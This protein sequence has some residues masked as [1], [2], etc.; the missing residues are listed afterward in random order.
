MTGKFEVRTTY[1]RFEQGFDFKFRLKM[2]LQFLKDPQNSTTKAI[3][4]FLKIVL[5]GMS[6]YISSIFI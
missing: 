3:K 5:V 4:K 6:F 1:K 2:D